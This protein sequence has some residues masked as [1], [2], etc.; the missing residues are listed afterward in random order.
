MNFGDPVTTFVIGLLAGPFVF[1][2]AIRQWGALAKVIA[3]IDPLARI[4]IG[5]ADRIKEYQ[6]AT[7]VP[8]VPYRFLGPSRSMR[9]NFTDFGSALSAALV[10]AAAA[11]A[12]VFLS[13][14]STWLA[15]SGS[16]VAV[17]LVAAIS[18]IITALN[19]WISD[20]TLQ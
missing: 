2:Y 15:G 19:K 3:G 17:A 11:A 8:V 1:S 9:F 16:V 20:N 18:G 6:T 12:V 13:S 4:F 14:I 10:T 5:C 7:K